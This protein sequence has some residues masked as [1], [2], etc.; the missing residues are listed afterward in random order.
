MLGGC[1]NTHREQQTIP[2]GQTSSPTNAHHTHTHT[3]ADEKK[4]TGFFAPNRPPVCVASVPA[5]LPASPPPPYLSS[6]RFLAL[7]FSETHTHSTIETGA[8]NC[9]MQNTEEK[10][11]STSHFYVRLGLTPASPQQASGVRCERAG[12]VACLP[13]LSTIDISMCVLFA[14]PPTGLLCALRARRPCR[15]PRRCLPYLSS[16]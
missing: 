13:Y 3:A 12:P 2:Q 1:V 8:T 7:A 5:P 6:H 16:Y 4:P 9:Y 15:L 14:F 10:Q 11:A